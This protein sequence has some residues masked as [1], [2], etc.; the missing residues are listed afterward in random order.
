MCKFDIPS[1]RID[2]RSLSGLGTYSL[3]TSG[4]V[5]HVKK[6]FDLKVQYNSPT[7]SK[8]GYTTCFYGFY[9]K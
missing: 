3:I 8:K 6:V 9:F 4:G 2:D 5:K 7:W 1:T